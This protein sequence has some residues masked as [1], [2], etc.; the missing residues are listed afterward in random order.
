MDVRRVSRAVRALRIRRGWRQADLA[1]EAKLSRSVVGRIERAERVGL[2]LDAVVAVAEALGA[3]VSLDLRWQGEGL[4]RLLD[5]GHATLVDRVVA[6][7]RAQGWDVAV[8]VSFA[9]GGERGSIDVLAWHPVRRA[10][11]V[12]E[13]KSVT[14]DMQAMLY[15]LAVS[16][17]PT[18][19]PSI[20][21]CTPAM[22]MLSLAV[23]D[24]VTALP[25][26]LAPLAGAVSATVG[27][28]RSG[29]K[30]TSTP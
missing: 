2:T 30:M 4:D 18:L 19:T 24:T 12:I 28:I 23:A 21:N 20:L 29:V 17:A 22:L 11:A 9:R 5:E 3:T 1:R 14:P 26:M 27:I 15:G 8:E 25:E 6:W 16:S 7:L 13:M 10:L